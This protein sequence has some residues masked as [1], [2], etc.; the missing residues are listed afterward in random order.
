MPK[1]DNLTPRNNSV[2]T[3]IAKA[4]ANMR[5]KAKTPSAVNEMVVS[6]GV[7]TTRTGRKGSDHDSSSSYE[8]QSH[9]SLSSSHQLTISHRQDSRDKS[10][11]TSRT[12]G[13]SPTSEWKVQNIPNQRDILTV[14][15]AVPHIKLPQQLGG[16][17]SKWGVGY[18]V[19]AHNVGLHQKGC[20]FGERKATSMAVTEVGDVEAS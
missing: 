4:T 8:R 20:Q 12:R 11:L 5:E 1:L 17:D 2:S 7:G 3:W 15:T 6:N 9:L 16:Q 18:L 13:W 14:I 19:Y 10:W